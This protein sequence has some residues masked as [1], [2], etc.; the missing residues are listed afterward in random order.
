[1]II[2]F[3]MPT[4]QTLMERYADMLVDDGHLFLGHSEAMNHMSD[5]Y[6]LAGKSVY[7]KGDS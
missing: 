7:I 5:S 4:K 2:Y 3:D 6:T 1:M